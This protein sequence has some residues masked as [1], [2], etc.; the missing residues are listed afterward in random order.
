[1]CQGKIPI[2]TG[3][4]RLGRIQV[5]IA[6]GVSAPC[7]VPAA[8][9][10]CLESFCPGSKTCTKEWVNSV[11]IEV[12]SVREITNKNGRLGRKFLHKQ[13]YPLLRSSSLTSALMG[14]DILF[15]VKYR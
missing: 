3:L 8:A 15:F 7:A 9:V 12:P 11:R 13:R 5:N 1:M 4:A 10:A 2:T 14:R 6:G